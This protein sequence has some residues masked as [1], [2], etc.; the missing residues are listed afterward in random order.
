MK[1]VEVDWRAKTVVGGCR[2]VAG[3]RS[4][5]KKQWREVQ[6][7]RCVVQGHVLGQNSHYS[8]TYKSLQPNKTD[9]K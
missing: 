6:K 5:V 7:Q 3:A 8:L 4:H 1:E 9:L 2:T